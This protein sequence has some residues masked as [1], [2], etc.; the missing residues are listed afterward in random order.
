MKFNKVLSYVTLIFFFFT[1]LGN[2]I[3]VEAYAD[4]LNPF[5]VSTTINGSSVDNLGTLNIAN[6]STLSLKFD[7]QPSYNVPVKAGDKITIQLPKV[8]SNLSLDT[9]NISKFFDIERKGNELT[10]I[11]KQA[12]TTMLNAFLTIGAQLKNDKEDTTINEPLNV[13]GTTHTIKINVEKPYIPTP[14][15]SDSSDNK[16]ETGNV[17]LQHIIK[18]VEGNKSM[19][20]PD[21]NGSNNTLSY[22]VEINTTDMNGNI[23]FTDKMPEGLQLNPDSIMIF[24]FDHGMHNLTSEL[25]KTIKFS[26]DNN[27][28]IMSGFKPNTIYY[29]DYSAEIPLQFANSKEN[30][31]ISNTAY[32][33]N[34]N[35]TADVTINTLPPKITPEQKENMIHKWSNQETFSNIGDNIE[36]TLEINPSYNRLQ[37][38]KLIDKLPEGLE[39]D[40][41]MNKVFNYSVSDVNGGAAFKLNIYEINKDGSVKTIQSFQDPD[42]TLYYN[43]KTNTIEA[44]LGNT[45]YKFMFW[46]NTKVTKLQASITNNATFSYNSMK[47]SSS[48][49]STYTSS[50]GAIQAWKT[51]NKATLIEGENPDVQ[52]QIHVKA[53]GFYPKN[54]ITIKDSLAKGIKLESV[55]VPQG[56]TYKVEGNTVIATN[57]GT[58]FIAGQ[59]A[60]V[61]LNCSLADFKGGTTIY[62]QAQVNGY[63]T[64]KVNTKKGYAFTAVKENAENNNQK[65]ESAVYGVYSATNNKLLYD[66]TSN[67]NGELTGQIKEP[68]D[69]YL[70]E[71]KAPKGYELSKDKIQFKITSEDIGTT[72]NLGNI[73]DNELTSKITVKKLS[74]E[75]N[76]TLKGAE[77]TITNSNGQVIKTITTG[78]NGIATADLYPGTY[79]IKEVKAPIGYVNSNYTKTFTVAF[80]GE[81][82]QE[83]TV[84]D[85]EVLGKLLITK[86]GSNGVKLNGAEF[87]VT[88]PNG[89]SKIVTTDTNG[90]ANLENLQWGT[91]NI[92]EVKAPIGYKLSNK[93]QS[94]IINSQNCEN[95]QN[96]IFNDTQILGKLN[97]TKTGKDG[98]KLAGA[99]FT[100]SG[101]NGF[102]EVVTTDKNGVANLDNLQWGT[103]K[104][105][106][107]KAPEG[108]NLNN[109]V[110]TVQVTSS[111]VGQ[112]QSLTFNDSQVLGRLNINKIGENGIKLAG[113]EFT[114]SGPNGFKEVVTTNKD[115]VASLENLQWGTYK[116]QETKAPIGYKLS[117]EVESIKIN[118]EDA[119][120]LQSLVFNDS[121]ILGQL[122]IFK[123]GVNGSR[124]S[125]AE[126]KV[127]G[128]NG[129]NKIVTTDK[130][131]VASLENLQWGTYKVQE[132]KA[133]EGYNLNNEVQ[134]VQVTNASV[135]QVQ[136]L[137]FNDTQVLGKLD[138]TKIGKDGVKLEGAEFDVTGPNG[139]N[140]IVTTNKDGVASLD[141][142]QWGTYKVQETKAPQ[143]YKLNENTQSIVINSTDVSNIQNI[144]VVDG[145][146][147]GSLTITKEGPNKEKLSGAV[148]EITGP[149]GFDR[150]VTTGDN[151]SIS[152]SGLPWGTYTIKEVK[153]PQGYELNNKP[154]KV[155]VNASNVKLNQNLIFTDAKLNGSIKVTKLG[156]DGAKLAGAEF[157]ITG[158]NNFKKVITT[159]INGVAT[160]NNL[161]WGTYTIKETKAPLGYKLSDKTQ[162]VTINSED[163][164][165]VQSL[166]FNDTQILGELNIIKTGKDG[167]KLE[168]AEFTVSGPN[169]FKEVVTTNKNGVASLENLQWGTYTIKETKAPLGYNLN[170]EVQT[171]QVTNASV[172]QIQSLTFN[173]TQ[174]LGKLNITKI[175]KDGVKLKGAEFTVSGPNGFKEVVTTN[176]NGVASL[177]NLQWGTYKV[178]E[179]KAPLGYNLNNEIKTVQVTNESVSQVQDLTF[180]D[181]QILGKLNITKT[182]KDGVK[183]EGAE[184]TVSGPNG[185]NKIV[186]TNKDGVASLDN[187]QWGI[188]TV[189]EVKAPQGYLLDSSSKVIHIN[190]T[191]V[192]KIQS[193]SFEDV[194]M[195]GNLEVTKLGKD[196]VKLAG[197][198]FQITG[199]NNFNKVIITNK[200]GIA[201]LNNL[202]W[203]TYEVKEIKAPLGYKLSD[204]TQSV[205]INSADVSQV[206]S[207]TFNDV[208]ILGQLNITK[209]GKDGV[210]LEG[211]QFTISGPNGFKEVVTTNKNGVASLNNLQWGTY[212]IK[213]TKAPLGYNL[214]PND[215]TVKID[216]N[217]ANVSQNIVIADG[218]I[219]GS[220][221][222]TKEGANKEK[223]AGAT[224][225]ITGPNGF[226]RAITTGKDGNVSISGLAWGTYT[227]K[228]IIAP[229]GYLVSKEEQKVV[230]DSSDVS[231]LQDVIFTDNKILGQINI[232]KTNMDGTKKLEG[233]TF[234]VTGPNGFNKVVTTD[235]EGAVSLTGLAWGTYEVKEIKAPKGYNLNDKIQTVTIN[236][237][238]A[239]MINYL[240]F[241]DSLIDTN[242]IVNHNVTNNKLN[243]KQNN[244]Q[245]KENVKNKEVNKDISNN[246]NNTNTN[247]N[248][249]S[250]S[251]KTGDKS[252]LPIVLVLLGAVIGLVVINRKQTKDKA[253]L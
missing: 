184:F 111:S 120:Q 208:Q 189:K 15:K 76:K 187:L 54:Y 207:L 58:S 13:D 7:I 142:L 2:V 75:T 108:Y 19:I 162:S 130:N 110:Q 53:Y 131:G 203:G 221:K 145:Q 227:I 134:T 188:Y 9:S 196:G 47:S 21:L 225:D 33:N 156:K 205:T 102:K 243:N 193:L 123:T 26:D 146:E 127:I 105:Q 190:S 199:E 8:F 244:K 106:E 72:V 57:S 36:Y 138:I 64:N 93:I 37:N 217:N 249:S 81:D 129:F 35:S 38:A 103:Y 67:A 173:D 22:E 14:P 137:T 49:T 32:L 126:F 247:I 74:I 222:I 4:T 6:G 151:G 117:N 242:K 17:P 70:K 68:G 89:F 209:I 228:E 175:G 246:I 10:L 34:Y 43:L 210:K 159:D 39:L 245:T 202:P 229:Q 132:T 234:D 87:K 98:V 5:N 231:K 197:A 29:L 161:P 194:R 230:I 172:G 198:E 77:F 239:K 213:E 42:G 206:Q 112:V 171:V 62:N 3:P 40:P 46:Y 174:I 125:G 56:F 139:F 177:E 100:V 119:S 218:Q 220:I 71:I 141:N 219:T 1:I 252:E 165:Q 90:V 28:I 60:V 211:A 144:T 250:E 107:T 191:N 154:Q 200:N 80:G 240:T 248:N 95:T 233:A 122:S 168:G 11:A 91:Y 85:S 23:N 223:L 251:P 88:G 183:L 253:K 97:I 237:E 186:T 147:T 65:L 163:V 24:S 235:K 201:S 133:P 169:G 195:T 52:Y 78:E 115:G 204:K 143:G 27:K 166:T 101:P 135:G 48:A 121:Q 82:N 114:V 124:L 170:N 12:A 66:V 16:G 79:T 215:Y 96:I 118:S 192:E 158:E 238:N 55:E 30:Y 214:N 140:K 63:N 232:T 224:F 176:K 152:L 212:T 181:T 236:S 157:T 25:G 51:V 148:F 104:V 59:S 109:E 179:T 155:E 128:P 83:F 116:V 241:K 94:V 18:T 150:E 84:K 226:N 73:Y 167:V 153:A 61:K 149:N 69:Y 44:D 31:K 182:G 216:S 164:S 113:A 136:D 20:I 92:Q 178:Q 160:L 50:S 41:D 185:F 45:A 180:N 86:I 99:E